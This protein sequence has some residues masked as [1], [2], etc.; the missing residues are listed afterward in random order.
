MEAFEQFVALAMEADGLLVSGPHKF[1]IKRKTKKQ[2]LDEFQS[3]GYEVDLVGMRKDKLV[4]A[5]VKS[6]FGSKGVQ[7][8]E[9]TNPDAPHGRG[10][11]MLNN[12]ELRSTLIRQAAE[13]FG[14]DESDVEL[15]LYAGKFP[16]VVQELA[17]R[18]WASRQKAG[19]GSIKVF[20]AA[21]VVSAVRV[22][23]NSTTYRDN[24]VLVS[25]K[26]LDAAGV[27][28]VQTEQSLHGDEL[29]RAYQ[30]TVI[31]FKAADG[32]NVSLQPT[33]STASTRDLLGTLKPGSFDAWIFT[34]E[35][36][37]SALLSTKENKAR[38]RELAKDLGKR[39]WDYQPA[40]G[41]SLDGDWSE[42][43]FIIWSR[44]KKESESIERHLEMLAEIYEQ[45]AFFRLFKSQRFICTGLSTNV[46][47]ASSHFTLIVSGEA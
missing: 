38:M 42:Q 43:S 3:H 44:N 32:R 5:T 22:M 12:V 33:A 15:R 2:N 14:Y 30:E 46:K 10:Y 21:Q 9:V 7:A 29:L 34:A 13:Q 8:K 31:S 20:G 16:S 24:P 11:A 19:A 45:N 36:P 25:L 41:S 18:E 27:L 35:N 47:G 37:K 23:A 39:S 28:P 17:I 6:F 4:L 1:M 26:V 40:V